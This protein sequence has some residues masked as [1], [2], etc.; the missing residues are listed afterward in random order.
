MLRNKQVTEK[1]P[2]AAVPR[3]AQPMV[4]CICS[5]H[6]PLPW[7]I[8]KSFLTSC[9]GVS[10]SQN[11]APG[12]LAALV[13]RYERTTLEFAQPSVFSSALLLGRFSYNMLN[14]MD[15]IMFPVSGVRCVI[16]LTQST[17]S[18]SVSLGQKFTLTCQASQGLVSYLSWYQQKT[19]K[20]TKNLMY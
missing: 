11:T 14:C 4:I 16:Q 18:L 20:A 1:S 7:E 2:L 6:S 13:P 12:H 5:E 15:V 10:P 19:R 9:F 17:S 8:K 3:T